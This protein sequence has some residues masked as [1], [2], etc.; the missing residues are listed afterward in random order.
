MHSVMLS[1]ENIDVVVEFEKRARETEAEIFT[2]EFDE[3]VFRKETLNALGNPNFASTR[4]MMCADENGDIIGR[5]DF[6][7]LPSFAFGGDIRAYVD[8][9]Y[10]LKAHR[11]KGVAQFLFNE[12][13]EY[14]KKLGIN[15][16]FLI[17]AENEEAQSFYRSLGNASIE[18]QDILSVNAS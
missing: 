12:M 8:W 7:L 17:A 2:F 11:H 13:T 9:V 1:I 3:M 15:D 18:K 16:Y 4:C 6:T 14:L 5:V 10:V